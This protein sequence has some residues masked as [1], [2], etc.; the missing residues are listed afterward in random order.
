MS[1]TASAWYLASWQLLAGPVSGDDCLCH[2]CEKIFLAG[3]RV[4]RNAY[5]ARRD[6][7]EHQPVATTATY[8][9]SISKRMHTLAAPA[10]HTTHKRPRHDRTLAVC[11][12]TTR[13]LISRGL[14]FVGYGPAQQRC[15]LQ[16]LAHALT[17]APVTAPFALH[18]IEKLRAPQAFQGSL[19]SAPRTSGSTAGLVAA[20]SALAGSALTA[21]P[22]MA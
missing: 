4:D 12:P 8:G 5:H 19:E 13:H 9:S 14:L 7:H 11:P 6:G 1:Q 20:L 15:M 18:Q 17:W 21:R 3:T 22:T 10:P 16:H 2:G